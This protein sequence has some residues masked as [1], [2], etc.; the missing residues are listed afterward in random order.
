MSTT[1][2]ATATS[3]A[4]TPTPAGRT[5]TLLSTSDT[6]LLS[7]RAS[8]AEYRWG[9]PARL[10]VEDLPELL[11]GADLVIVRILG[12]KRAWEEGLDVIRASGVPMV[13]L[14]GE[15]APDAELMECSTVPVGVAAW[16]A[17]PIRQTRP[18]LQLAMGSKSVI[19]L[20]M[21]RPSSA[22]ARMAGP[23]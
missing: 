18:W 10:L 14:G 16:A 22:A 9:N 11:D 3:T 6:D 15:I 5:F 20:R 12:G 23:G 21:M 8:G 2:P 7:A 17:S 13:A 1:T 4:R 19:S